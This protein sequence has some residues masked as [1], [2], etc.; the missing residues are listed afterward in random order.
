MSSPSSKHDITQG[1]DMDTVYSLFEIKKNQLKMIHRRG[2]DIS[3]EQNLL[4]ITLAQFEEAYIPFAQQQN[5]TLREV[6]SNVYQNEAGKRIL[7]FYA[8]DPAVTGESSIKQVEKAVSA[9]QTYKVR[10][11]CYISR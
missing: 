10:D 5:K 8:D 11:A 2:Y 3:R 7:V 9:M 6:L 1:I 4:Y